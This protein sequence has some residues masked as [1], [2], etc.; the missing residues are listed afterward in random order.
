LDTPVFRR[1]GASERQAE[2]NR[3]EAYKTKPKTRKT[4]IK[5]R[6]EEE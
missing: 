3:E 6:A 5:E 1:R 4:K 2:G